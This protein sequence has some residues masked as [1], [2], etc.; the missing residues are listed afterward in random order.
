MPNFDIT[1][2]LV[3]LRLIVVNSNQNGTQYNILNKQTQVT[4]HIAR[5]ELRHFCPRNGK[6][7]RINLSS[8]TVAVK[9]I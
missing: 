2:I 5:L 4:T 7:I 6:Q 9:Y 1:I 3:L 8:A